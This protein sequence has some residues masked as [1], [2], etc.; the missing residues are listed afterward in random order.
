[1]SEHQEQSYHGNGNHKWEAVCPGLRPGTQTMRLRVV[2]GW[3]YKDD[4]AIAF[5]GLPEVL[6]HKV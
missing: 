5:C 2:G 1:M 4:G 3:L 6:K